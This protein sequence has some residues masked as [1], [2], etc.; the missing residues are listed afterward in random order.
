M[1][2]R[3]ERFAAVEPRKETPSSVAA[4]RASNAGSGMTGFGSASPSVLGFLASFSPSAC[5]LKAST[6]ARFSASSSFTCKPSMF[7]RRRLYFTRPSPELSCS[8]SSSGNSKMLP[9]AVPASSLEPRAVRSARASCSSMCCRNSPAS[10][11]RPDANSG[12]CLP[13][14]ARNIC[15]ATS[16]CGSSSSSPS[17]HGGAYRSLSIPLTSFATC[18]MRS[19]GASCGACRRTLRS[20][21]R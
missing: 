15:G 13:M 20:A 18:V 11:W 9:N 1:A 4:K 21:S 14:S 2:A 5:A 16:S 6:S 8:R 3:R 17:F 10:C 7:C 12:C 19:P